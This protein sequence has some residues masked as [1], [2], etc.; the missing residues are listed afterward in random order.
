MRLVKPASHYEYA[1]DICIIT[2][3]FNPAS[4]RS[5]L[6]NFKKF[7]DPIRKSGLNYII[8]E[9]SFHNRGFEIEDPGHTIRVNS[10]DILW[11]KERLLN[12]SLQHVPDTC[13]KI[14]WIDSDIL[15]TNPRWAIET[16]ALLE[17]YPV[18]QPYEYAIRMPRNRTNYSEGG[19]TYNSFGLVYKKYPNALLDGNFNKHGHTGF[20]WAGRKDIFDEL[21][22]YDASISGVADHLMAHSFCGDWHSPCVKRM[23]LENDKFFSH[24]QAW[25]EKMYGRIRGRI[26]YCSGTIL[27]LWHG[28]AENRRYLENT[29]FLSSTDFDPTEDLHLNETCCWELR[30]KNTDLASWTKSYLDHRQED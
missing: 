17:E 30:K 7:I 15:F 28:S 16:S 8:V 12:I 9:C 22:L 20:V 19:H 25:S 5:K 29:Q 27:H 4:Y 6:R 24:F 14:V 2:S 21:G 18:I 26:S 13:T 11:Q 23:F 3:Y 10:N 1:E